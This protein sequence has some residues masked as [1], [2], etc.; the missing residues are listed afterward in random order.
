MVVIGTGGDVVD[1]CACKFL[2]G[3][4]FKIHVS[5]TP[6][7]YDH[8]LFIG[9]G[10]NQS[11][12]LPACKCQ[13]SDRSLGAIST[14]APF[15]LVGRIGNI[16]GSPISLLPS[17][18]STHR[19]MGPRRFLSPKAWTGQ[20]GSLSVDGSRDDVAILLL[21]SLTGLNRLHI[22]CYCAAA[23]DLA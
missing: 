19:L 12:A 11:L 13:S 2:V 8:D 18:S 20:S 6:D 4:I 9:I 16:I 14:L 10:W 5:P 1:S 7:G 23:A 3:A 21:S 15:T 22:P 17:L